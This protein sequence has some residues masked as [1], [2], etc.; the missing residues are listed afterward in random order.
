MSGRGR[1]GAAPDEVAEGAV[2][3]GGSEG[4]S[5]EGKEG[6]TRSRATIEDSALVHDGD[7]ARGEGMT[8]R[9]ALKV[10]A[11][12]AVLGAAGGVAGA[13]APDREGS[14]RP[15]GV[16]SRAE[17]AHGE[18]SGFDPLPPANPL[19]A[20]T[21]TDPDLLDPVVPWEMVLTDEELGQVAVLADLIIPAD[22]RSPAASTVGAADFVNEYVSAPG[23]EW[24]LDML[25]GGLAWLNR[26]A[27]GRFGQ[28]GFADVSESRR[29]EIC[30]E[31]CYA[32]EAPAALRG[33]AR[34][35]DHFRDLVSTAFWTTDEGMRDLGYVGN[36]PLPSFDGPPPEILERLGL[37]G[38]DL[39]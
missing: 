5:E 2:G 1:D 39:V 35:F 28:P 38:E 12:G 33:Q 21:P 8:R 16:A 31:I 26:E 13:C 19:A 14:G 37:E 6:M 3:L 32:P 24:S 23:H 22:D 34:F 27:R 25:R 17:A 20:G 18:L 4:G 36:V 15:D 7:E 9:G 10:I 30:D 29:R 11:G